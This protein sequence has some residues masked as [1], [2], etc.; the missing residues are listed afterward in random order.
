MT[1]RFAPS[2]SGDLHLGGARTALVAWLAARS[3]GG[4][5]LVRME[6]LDR[7]RVVRGA[8][9]RILEDLHSLG[10]DWDG[11]VVRQSERIEL[12]ENA[13]SKL[14]TFPCWCSRADLAASAPHGDEGPRY[15]GTCRDRAPLPKPASRR[16][17]VEPGVLDWIDLVRGEQHDDPSQQV[18]DFVVRRADG[19]FTYQLAVVVDDAAQG[20][21]EVVRGDDLMS[22]TARQIHLY[23]ALGAPVPQF[24]HVPLILGHDG[25]RLSKRHGSIAVREAKDVIRRLAASLGLE[26]ETPRELLEQFSFEKLPRTP[27]VI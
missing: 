20:V 10:L 2:P 22:S 5:F 3:A 6:D 16:V 15:P 12:Y 25:Q 9:E 27:T 24:A 19:V 11:P 7:P 18:G 8:E 26:G 4:T 1:G 13:L 23:R 17:R 14:D 21:T